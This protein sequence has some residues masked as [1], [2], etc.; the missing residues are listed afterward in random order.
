MAT[1]TDQE[2][3]K[4]LVPAS[5]IALLALV[6]AGVIGA[7][8]WL[9]PT[10]MQVHASLDGAVA[11]AQN[12]RMQDVPANQT[13]AVVQIKDAQ[14]T[15]MLSLLQRWGFFRSAT[16]TKLKE[17]DP[18]RL[19]QQSGLQATSLPVDWDQL[20]RL[21]YPCLLD[22]KE[23]D[24]DVRHAVALMRLS[25]TE[26]VILD[27]LLGRRVVSRADLPLRVDGDAL[28]LWKALPGITVPL[29]PRKGRDPVVAALQQ[30][31]HKQGLL[32]GAVTGLYDAPTR[33]AVARLQATH[34]LKAT[35][36][37]GVRSSMVLSKRVMGAKAPS[38]KAE[39]GV[40]LQ[41]SP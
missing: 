4:V 33:A 32:R 26:A 36:R 15:A 10:W 11:P 23:N 22:W 6:C 17:R 5:W 29:R 28:I 8:Y 38:L 16:V 41:S 30:A 1:V 40:P 7:L 19:I 21:D 34:G 24:G 9:G 13:V 18:A 12:P 25:A 27:P 14:L 39:S 2:R 35:G 37:F 3:P 31:L 20:A